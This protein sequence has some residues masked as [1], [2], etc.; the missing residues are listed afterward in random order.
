MSL[1]WEKA[2]AIDLW[3]RDPSPNW[4]FFLREDY[5]TRFPSNPYGGDIRSSDGFKGIFWSSQ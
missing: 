5:C 1:S 3:I 2:L 4:N